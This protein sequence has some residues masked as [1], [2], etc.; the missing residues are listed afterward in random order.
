MMTTM[1]V[2]DLRFKEAMVTFGMHSL[3]V[4]QMLNSWP[5]GYSTKLERLGYSRGPCGKMRL[6]PLNNEVGLQVLKFPKTK[7][8]ERAIMLMYKTIYI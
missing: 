2:L 1:Q 6:G 5:T 4:R 7:F 8:L 3:F